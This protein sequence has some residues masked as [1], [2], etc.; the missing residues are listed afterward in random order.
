MKANRID[1]KEIDDRG[2]AK[3]GIENQSEKRKRRFDCKP[4]SRRAEDR[5]YHKDP[6]DIQFG[7]FRKNSPKV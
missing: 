3:D 7:H 1:V 4:S 5:V 2:R 6:S